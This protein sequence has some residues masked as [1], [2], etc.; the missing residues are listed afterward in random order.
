MQSTLKA[1]LLDV[2][3][4]LL[5]SNDAHARSWVEVLKRHRH[6][7]AYARVRSLIG[8]GGDKMLP[9]LIHV[10][11]DQAEFAKISEERT[12]LFSTSYLPGLRP[13]PGARALL[14]QMKSEGLILIVATS[15]GEELSALLAQ[16]GVADLIE[17]AATSEDAENSKPDADIV[18]A[19]LE[20]AGVQAQQAVMLGD[21]PYDIQAARSA[22]VRAISFRCGGWWKDDDF[23]GALAIY[24]DPAELLSKWPLPLLEA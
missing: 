23:T 12:A 3:G 7:C 19:A 2:D 13:T 17:L 24:D 16:A 15:A 11:P 22:G 10:T 6:V 4:T 18:H 21:T 14:E 9:E 20:K 8:K 5:D 1:V